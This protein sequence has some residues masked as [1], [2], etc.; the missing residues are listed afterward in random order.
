MSTSIKEQLAQAVG[1][2]KDSLIALRARIVDLLEAV[3][4]GVKLSDD[5]GLVIKVVRV[6][7][8]A[9]QWSN[10]TWDLTIKGRGF[11][12]AE[13]RLIAEDL[14]GSAWDGSNM[15]YRTTEPTILGSQADWNIND[16]PGLVRA[17]GKDTRTIAARL[18]EA[19]AR[20]MADC[21]TERAENTATLV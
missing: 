20:Y 4:I 15:H 14:D 7:T 10:Q 3:P 17:N 1:A 16:A 12:D 5:A 19:I 13:G 8:G 18:P 2:R 9:S 6:C 21:E 11:L